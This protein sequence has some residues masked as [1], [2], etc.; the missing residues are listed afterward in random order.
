MGGSWRCGL[1]SDR[2]RTHLEALLALL[3]LLLRV[4]PLPL[5]RQLVQAG[6]EHWVDGAPWDALQQRHGTACLQPAL[7]AAMVTR[8]QRACPA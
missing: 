8:S 3:A 4:A 2:L 1:R 6:L 7:C 5:H